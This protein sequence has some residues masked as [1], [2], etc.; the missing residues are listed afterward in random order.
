M[1][2]HCSHP[3]IELRVLDVYTKSDGSQHTTLL[4][5]LEVFPE[6]AVW[7][8]KLDHTRL[9]HHFRHV[10]FVEDF[11]FID[12][13]SVNGDSNPEVNST[14]YWMNQRFG[15]SPLFFRGIISRSFTGN[16]SLTRRQHGK[17][18]SLDGLYRFS[19]GLGARMTR[20]W[21]S[22]SLRGDQASTYIIHSCPENA[23]NAML[24]CTQNANRLKLLRPLAV[25]AFLAEDRLDEWGKDVIAPRD[26]LVQYENSKFSLYNSAQV[27]NAVENLH[28]L[29]QLLHVIKGHLADLQERLRYLVTVHQRLQHLTSRHRRRHTTNST[30]PGSFGEMHEEYTDDE[31]EQEDT[32]STAG[33]MR[34]VTNYNERTGIRINLFFNIST[35]T[36]SRINLD[37]ARLTSKIAVS[38][39]RDSSSMITMAAVTMFFLPGTFISALFSMV[40]FDTQ[41]NGALTVSKQAWLFPAITIP[42]TI[43]V[44]VLWVVWQRYRSRVDARSLGLGNRASVFEDSNNAEKDLDELLN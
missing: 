25:D 44:F 43:V 18:V 13:L 16:A 5:L 21:F 40:F 27:A 36:D 24:L 19:S 32:D 39:Q 34:W 22:H 12:T 15:V 8:P 42:L 35:Q 20:V 1:A 37:I 11:N 2:Q 17:R 30:Y 23:K 3:E 28:A 10:S 31:E 38:T 9:V 41:D 6:R 29:S 26:E 33:L 14:A 7:T 4:D